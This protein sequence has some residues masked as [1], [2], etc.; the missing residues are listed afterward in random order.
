M[1]STIIG[2]GLVLVVGWLLFEAWRAWR[3]GELDECLRPLALSNSP[4]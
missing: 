3:R 4:L 1:L 2:W